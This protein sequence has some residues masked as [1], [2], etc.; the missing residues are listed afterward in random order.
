LV[1][2]PPP[3]FLLLE[4]LSLNPGSRTT[5]DHI[6][7]ITHI[8]SS[9][10]L[11]NPLGFACHQLEVLSLNPACHIAPAII[12]HIIHLFPSLLI[13]LVIQPRR[14]VYQ[15]LL[16]LISILIIPIASIGVN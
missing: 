15:F 7:H 9:P 5:L 13:S 2:P 16:L 4:V 1:L 14:R 11:F 8:I 10:L 6:T 12:I 3:T